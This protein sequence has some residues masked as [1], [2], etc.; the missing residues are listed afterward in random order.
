MTKRE[1]HY[2]AAF[3]AYLR[4]RETPYVAVD[5]TRRALWGGGSLKSLDFLVARPGGSG[6]WLVDVKGR[7]FPSGVKRPRSGRQPSSAASPLFRAGRAP[8]AASG[9][10]KPTG[11]YWRNWSTLDDL[12]SLARWE[13]LLGRGFSGVLLF[14][15]H[16]IGQL[17]PLPAEQLFEFRERIYGFV[18]VHLE[19]YTA[20]A[21]LLSQ[22]WNTVGL[23]PEEFRQLAVPADALFAAARGAAVADGGLAAG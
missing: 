13:Q 5:E 16:V 17:A 18:A 20:H 2:E 21:R 8:A 4:R 1:N 15:F 7:R 9:G 19:H 22:K 11:T 12:C 3:E 14:A 23:A 10:G 6:G